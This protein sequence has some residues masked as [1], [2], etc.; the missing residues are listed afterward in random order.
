MKRLT[1]SI[2]I[3]LMALTALN[4]DAR[5]PRQE[6]GVLYTRLINLLATSGQWDEQNLTD[7]GL[8]KIFSETEEDEECGTF[9]FFVYGKNTKVSASEGWKVSLE[10]TGSHAIAIE[11]TLM[12]DNLTK[13]CFKEK[14]DHDAFMAYVKK[15]KHYNNNGLPYIGLSL[16]ESDEFVN[17]WYVISIHG[18]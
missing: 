16:I 15:S 2:M 3:I 18:G 9:Y 4:A 6:R 10:A 11:V 14:A 12:T 1:L 13:L 17:N 5:M 7:I 8:K